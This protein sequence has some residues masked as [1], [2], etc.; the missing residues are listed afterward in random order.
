MILEGFT[1]PN[2]SMIGL[3]LCFDIECQSNSNLTEQTLNPQC[4]THSQL[5]EEKN[6]AITCAAES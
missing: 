2:D 1:N 5:Q 3:T 6:Q 4:G